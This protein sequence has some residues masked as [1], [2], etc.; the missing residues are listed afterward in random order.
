[1]S[2]PFFNPPPFPPPYPASNTQP[3]PAGTL[4]SIMLMEGHD[5]N[6][7][8]TFHD[9]PVGNHELFAEHQ[10]PYLFPHQTMSVRTALFLL[11]AYYG[12]SAPLATATRRLPEHVQALLSGYRPD[13]MLSSFIQVPTLWPDATTDDVEALLLLGSCLRIRNSPAQPN[14][15]ALRPEIPANMNI[16]SGAISLHA[17]L[18]SGC[19][20][21]TPIT[22][23]FVLILEWISPT[24]PLPMPPLMVPEVPVIAA[25]HEI[26]LMSNIHSNHEFFPPIVPLTGP[27]APTATA[28]SESSS[29]SSATNSSPSSFPSTPNTPTSLSAPSSP[30][31]SPSVASKTST[32]VSRATS[33]SPAILDAE[34]IPD[35]FEKLGIDMD[36]FRGIATG[37][38][39]TLTDAIN[40]YER[41]GEILEAMGSRRLHTIKTVRDAGSF[42]LTSGI[43]HQFLDVLVDPRYLRWTTPRAYIDKARLFRWCERAARQSWNPDY[44]AQGPI[45]LTWIRLKLLWAR[46]WSGNLE[47]PSTQADGDEAEAAELRA[48]HLVES[49]SMLARSCLL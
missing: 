43:T 40:L 24:Y 44:P 8:G 47:S 23:Y 26:P 13:A 15:F 39:S 30:A 27:P 16:I 21:A 31:T 32:L 2:N 29:H 9:I 11:L 17:H 3:A 41:S 6:L 37:C 34:T 18:E 14:I 36:E 4:V 38:N 33:H 5:L 49:K 25:S 48:A 22:N 28:N 46:R 12:H 1:M 20:P 10:H 35:A 7:L 45:Y 42:T 19:F